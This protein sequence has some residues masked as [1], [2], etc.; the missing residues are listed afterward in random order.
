MAGT[1]PERIAIEFDALTRLLAAAHLHGCADWGEAE[2]K[3]DQDIQSCRREAQSTRRHT[4][5]VLPRVLAHL[6]AA[7]EN[8]MRDP[9]ADDTPWSRQ[10]ATDVAMFEQ[11][12]LQAP[13][14]RILR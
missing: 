9:Q 5:A 4:V 10:L 8:A 7:A 1:A 13:E 6:L 3:A 14:A 11:D 12:C 2:K